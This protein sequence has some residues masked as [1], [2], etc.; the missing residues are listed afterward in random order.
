MYNKGGKSDL[1]MKQKIQTETVK[2]CTGCDEDIVG[3]ET[4]GYCE[5]CLCPECGNTLETENERGVMMCE[6]CENN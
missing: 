2:K 3:F 5:N 1:N 6:E 4:N